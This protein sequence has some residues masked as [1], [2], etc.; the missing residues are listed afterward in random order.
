MPINITKQKKQKKIVEC[1]GLILSY[2]NC[3]RLFNRLTVRLG[4]RLINLNLN[5]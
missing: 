3:K 2:S 1:L 4:N 5:R